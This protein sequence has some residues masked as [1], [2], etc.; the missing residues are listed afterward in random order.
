[1][2]DNSKRPEQEQ[3]RFEKLE[4]LVESGF[5][6]PN[7]VF[8]SAFSTDLLNTEIKEAEQSER[9]TIAGRM[10][11]VRRMGKAAFAHILDA[12]GK[13]QVYLR[14]DDV[15]EAAYEQFNSTDIGDLF[16]VK[17]YLFKTKTGETTLYAEGVRLLSK[18][19][20]PLPEKWHGLQD[21]EIR[22]RERYLDLISNPDVREVFKT[23]ARIISLLRQFLDRHD[24]L[25]VETPVLYGTAGGAVARPFETIYNALDAKMSLRIALELPLKKLVVGGLDRVYE[26]GRVFRNEGFS[27]KH[28]PE[29]T[30]LEFYC[31]YLDFERM[32][33]FVEEMLSTVVKEITGS[34]KIKYADK[35]VDFTPPWTRIS[36][37]DSIHRIGGVPDSFN[38]DTLE[39]ALLAAKEYK[40]EIDK[41]DLN[42]WGRVLDALW[43]E[44]VEPKLIN[45]TFI[46]HHPYSISPLARK[47]KQDPKTTDRFEL[48]VAS[49]ELV[50]AFSELNDP[51]DQRQRFVEQIDRK[52]TAND[53]EANAI[54]E[55]FL[56]A[57]EFGLPPTAGTGVGIDRLVM[58]L[59]DSPSIREV[60]LFPQLKPLDHEEKSEL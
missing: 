21:V 40:V 29:F 6:Y 26:I 18:A 16:E 38:L 11:Q 44:L 37:H 9:F 49:M 23:R 60:L 2:E 54:D 1:M 55:D 57:I 35:E 14:K 56:R 34:T 39:G 47:N 46:T 48:I 53:N 12:K 25:E 51:V 19:L 30:M 45:P 17:G 28:N 41:Q 32:M 50:N 24:Y 59:T 27:K 10:V 36:M 31:A 43:G 4:K 13:I 8:Q 7:D 58:L 22:Y 15:G 42:D 3:V 20:I 52:E 5:D 33:E